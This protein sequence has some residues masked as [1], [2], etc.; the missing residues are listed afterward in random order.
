[1]KTNQADS[2]RTFSTTD[3]IEFYSR[4]EIVY[5]LDVIIICK[6]LA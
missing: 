2:E 4:K 3:H 1:M 5:Y 6:T